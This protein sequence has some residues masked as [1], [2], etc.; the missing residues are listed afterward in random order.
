VIVS[1]A[2]SSGTGPEVM[3][4]GLSPAADGKEMLGK[5]GEKGIP[6]QSSTIAQVSYF[7]P[8]PWGDHAMDSSRPQISRPSG[9][10]YMRPCATNIVRAGADRCR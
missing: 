5:G 3:M 6:N 4:A 1:S 7:Q 2:P 8:A 9:Q 10:S